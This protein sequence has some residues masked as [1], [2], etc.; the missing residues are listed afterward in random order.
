M[1]KGQ[2]NVQL[3]MNIVKIIAG[4][5]LVYIILKALNLI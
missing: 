3:L 4:V 5:I 1:K 2:I